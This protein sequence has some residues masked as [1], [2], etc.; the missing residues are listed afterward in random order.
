MNIITKKDVYAKVCYVSKSGR[1]K[2]LS[3]HES[4]IFEV[5]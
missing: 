4:I 3:S 2:P 1:K 5:E